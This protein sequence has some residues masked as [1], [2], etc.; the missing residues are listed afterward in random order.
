MKK[1]LILLAAVL[2]VMGL[3]GC[4]SPETAESPEVEMSVPAT[5]LPTV[6]HTAS[7]A[8]TRVQESPEAA[9]TEI[10][11]AEI[12]DAVES[13]EPTMELTVEPEVTPSAVTAAE[14]PSDEEVLRVYRKA[15]E[16]YSW[17]AGYGD[18]GLVLDPEDTQARSD[19]TYFKVTASDLNSVND[20]RAYLK[21]M[22]S[23]EVVDGLLTTGQER[24]L[25]MEGV[26]YALPAGRVADI[27]KGGVTTA[28]LWPEEATH[29]NCTVQTT[30]E[31]LDPNNNF[32]V[33]GEQVYSFPYVQVG[34]KWVFTQ[35]ESIF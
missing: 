26:L 19:L 22:F 34:D 29:R 35:F 3:E 15:T 12:G 1:Y 14:G 32:A 18:G 24:F 6:F 27:T 30:V 13:V 21:T 17:F 20:V 25:E 9:E 31:V 11:P 4:R 2:A 8:P 28:V 23:D 7:A 16:A 10:P 5:V 33:T